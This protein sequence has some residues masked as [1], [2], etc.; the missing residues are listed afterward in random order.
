M[1]HIFKTQTRKLTRLIDWDD[2]CVSAF[3]IGKAA[4]ITEAQRARKG[5]WLSVEATLEGCLCVASKRFQTTQA[6]LGIA[7]RSS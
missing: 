3:P 7:M 5:R 2:K 6:S 4:A 1:R